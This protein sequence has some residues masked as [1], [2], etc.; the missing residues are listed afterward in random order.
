[1]YFFPFSESKNGRHSSGVCSTMSYHEYPGAAL[2]RPESSVQ[3]SPADTIPEF[4]QRPHEGTKRPSFIL[5]EN[6]SDVF[7]YDPLGIVSFDHAEIGE[8]QLSSRV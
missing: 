7:P 5:I 1:M 3:D 4:F 6:A 8:N 2:G